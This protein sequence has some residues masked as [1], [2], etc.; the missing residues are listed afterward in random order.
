MK[1]ATFFLVI[2]VWG[3]L[4]VTMN[5]WAQPGY[6]IEGEREVASSREAGSSVVRVYGPDT[7]TE[8]AREAIQEERPD[9]AVETYYEPM[10]NKV[11]IEGTTGTRYMPLSPK[12]VE[13]MQTARAKGGSVYAAL[14]SEQKGVIQKTVGEGSDWVRIERREYRTERRICHV[15]PMCPPP[16]P[17]A[18]FVPPVNVGFVIGGPYPPTGYRAYGIWGGRG[19]HGYRAGRAHPSFYPAHRGHYPAAPFYRGHR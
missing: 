13:R 11:R 9:V 19:D 5:S 1:K 14:C 12:R 7:L 15:R 4:G 2:I 18:I 8:L 10:R 16:L 3:I 6:Q 17:P